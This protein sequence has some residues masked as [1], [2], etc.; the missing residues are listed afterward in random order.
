MNTREGKHVPKS[1]P[2]KGF[3]L[4]HDGE[5]LMGVPRGTGIPA[6]SRYKYDALRTEQ[7]EQINRIY[8]ILRE[9]ISGQWSVRRFNAKDGS[10][11][12]IWE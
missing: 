3:I 11:R 10:E 8:R 9:R 7:I 5:Y 1:R 2:L 6:F 12:V 4:W